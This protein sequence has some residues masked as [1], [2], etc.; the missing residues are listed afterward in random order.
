MLITGAGGFVG[1]NLTRRLLRDGHETHVV[2]RP[3]SRPWRLE[4]VYQDLRLHEADV[5][6]GAR[7]GALVRAVRPEWVFHLAAFGAYPTQQGIDRMVA[8]NLMGAVALINACIREGV[9][10]FVQT[11]SSSEYGFQDHPSAE[12]DRIEPNSDYAVTKAAATHY[13]SHIG[14]T[15]VMNAITLRLY[16]IYGP[17][18]D[19]DRLIP[20]LIVH[21]LRGGFPPLV[22]PQTARDFVYVED[23]VSAILRTAAVAGGLPRGGV[24]NVASGVQSTLADVVGRVRLL[25][26]IDAEP[27]WSTMP[28][29]C[30]DTQVWI[31][32]TARMAQDVGWR[33][34]IGLDE[35]L[36][37]T[38]GWLRANPRWLPYYNSRV[39]DRSRGAGES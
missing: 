1:A 18:E 2:V 23:A 22:S 7:I 20:N 26:R 6:D 34:S 25:L 12:A 11:G 27:S 32:S 36:E 30:W 19:A 33:A 9:E 17:Y 29:R 4:E 10:T 13:C 21:G 38:I 28:Q 14:R 3:S 15:A 5:A 24:Y 35:G 8:T 31:G 16:S 39:I 37:R